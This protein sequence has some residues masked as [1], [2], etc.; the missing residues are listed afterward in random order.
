MNT[1]FLE[2]FVTLCRLRSFRATARM[3][4]ATP[5]TISM[6]VKALE[7]GLNVPLIDR[8]A[9]IFQLTPKGEGVLARAQT[10][11]DAT[12]ALESFARSDAPLAGQLRIGVV[13]TVVHTWL[14]N[15]VQTLCATYPHMEIDLTVDTSVRLSAGLLAHSLDLGI[16]AQTTNAPGFVSTE[17][18]SHPVRW[19]ARRDLIVGSQRDV[20]SQILDFPIMLHEHGL[21]PLGSAARTLAPLIDGTDK[22]LD[23]LRVCTFPSIALII[24]LLRAGY[25]VAAISSLC[26]KDQ[27]ASGELVVLDVEKQPEPLV[28]TV[29][30]PA[31]ATELVVAAANAVQAVS[32]SYGRATAASSAVVA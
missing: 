14:P 11:L 31:Q 28:L 2:T 30:R 29:A 32:K 25:G 24:Q 16:Q 1:K 20:V 9:P 8:S 5:A 17:L 23:Q 15:F 26:V 22:T 27:L 19:V 7:E 3:M 13:D 10:L 21:D 4:H 6:R 18:P 12:R